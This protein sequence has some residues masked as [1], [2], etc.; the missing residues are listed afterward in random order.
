MLFKSA[1]SWFSRE[2]RE[3]AAPKTQGRKERS[4]SHK[5]FYHCR[6]PNVSLRQLQ[7]MITTKTQQISLEQPQ[8]T[9]PAQEN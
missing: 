2:G 4:S 3:P 6:L 1:I 5:Q 9:N 7:E 8:I